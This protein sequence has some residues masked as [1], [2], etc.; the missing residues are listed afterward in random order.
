[1]VSHSKDLQGL[2]SKE[3]LLMEGT[4]PQAATQGSTEMLVSEGCHSKLHKLGNLKQQRFILPQFLGAR[5]T[6]S[7]YWQG[8]FLRGALRKIHSMPLS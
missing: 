1:M 3:G 5:S 6:D 2:T 7:K 4:S 8:S